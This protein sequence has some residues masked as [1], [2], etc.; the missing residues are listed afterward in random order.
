MPSIHLLNGHK[1]GLFVSPC[2]KMPSQNYM[3]ELSEIF[4]IS[5]GVVVQELLTYDAIHCTIG[6]NMGE[7][8]YGAVIA[9]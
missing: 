3:W 7:A 1:I 8:S 4:F 6:I 9:P 5:M 2:L